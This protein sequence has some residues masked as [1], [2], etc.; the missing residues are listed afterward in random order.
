MIQEP[1][2]GCPLREKSTLHAWI[3]IGM[4][5]SLTREK[6]EANT[7]GREEKHTLLSLEEKANV[8]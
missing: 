1:C 8:G 6:N 3:G 4:P 7:Q 5:M 2:A